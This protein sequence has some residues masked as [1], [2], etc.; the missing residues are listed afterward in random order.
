ML[1]KTRAEF[2][3]DKALKYGALYKSRYSISFGKD[4]MVHQQTG[5]VTDASDETSDEGVQLPRTYIVIK[6]AKHVRDVTVLWLVNKIRG[7]RR[8]G[9]AELVVRQ[10]PYDPSEGITLHVSASKIKFLEVAEQMELQKRDRTDQMR[11]FIVGQLEDF[12]EDGMTVDDLFSV[13]ERQTMVRHELENI[14]ALAED[15]YVPGYNSCVL[16][17]G[18]SI[19]QACQQCGVISQ[20]YSLHDKDA[21]K[22]LGRKWY[23]SLFEN[24]PIEDIRLY[25]GEAIALYFTFLGFYT[26]ALLVPMLLGFIQLLMSTE[27][28]PFFCVFNVVWVTVFLEVW[29]RRSN[30]LAFS[31]GTIG[32]TSL[33]EPRPNYHGQMGRDPVSGKIQPQYPR[34]KTNVKMYLISIP[35]VFVC[36]CG[37]FVIMLASFWLEELIKQPELEFSTHLQ[38]VPSIGYAAL[39]YVMNTYYR[40]LATYL[41]E[42]ENHRTQ[43]QYDRHRVTKLVMF[44]FVNNFM[45]LFYIAFVIQDMD[46][47]RSQLA[48]M[49]IIQQAISHF[50]EAI[51][52]LIIRVYMDKIAHWKKQFFENTQATSGKHL[53]TGNEISGTSPLTDV[54]ELPEDDTNIA[55]ATREG[56]MDCYEG[57]FDDYLEMFVQFGYVVLFSSVYPVAAFW[58]V[59][60]NIIEIRADAFKLCVAFQ[61]PMA[62]KVK[63]IGAWQK[64]FEIVGAMS[65]MTNC[66]LL[67][68]SPRMRARFQDLD[69]G[70]WV[71]VFVVLEHVLLGVR[72]VLHKGIADRPEWVRVEV[73]RRIYESRQALKN[74]RTQRSR[75]ILT[76][77]FKTVHG[78]HRNSTA[79]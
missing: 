4:N 10:E 27:T 47:L 42:W 77:R 76:R 44:E 34:W 28:V 33:D 52:P 15:V 18:Q 1:A 23:R 16:Y 29:K 73:A 19:L 3:L 25:F 69:A 22:K 11:E 43:S 53:K 61:R 60:N 6:V 78:P 68:L 67:A 79:T 70:T 49:L 57:T 51:L 66:G 71:L 26:T 5:D 46:M 30:E 40:K 65:I 59:L 31:W 48:I 56:E 63:D 35:I 2:K 54:P 39:V 50:Q 74:E 64:A 75:R 58:A 24:Q 8:D 20:L 17:E 62:R 41:T 21:L 38:L 7:K 55:E 14:R 36:M 37:A 72:F 45:S 32:M 13:S 12:L 9:G